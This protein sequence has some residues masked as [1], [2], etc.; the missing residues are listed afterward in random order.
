M[1]RRII[2]WRCVLFRLSSFRFVFGF[3]EMMLSVFTV[4]R[5]SRRVR[6]LFKLR[7]K[8]GLMIVVRLFYRLGLDLNF[9]NSILIF[10]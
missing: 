5:K 10:L 6:G 9:I 1:F 8:L 3:T 2:T 7:R 4:N